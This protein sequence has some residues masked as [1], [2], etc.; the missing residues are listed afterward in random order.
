MIELFFLRKNLDDAIWNKKV[1][2]VALIYI[3]IEDFCGFSQ[4]GFI[5]FA[6]GK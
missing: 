6:G 4:G 1:L 5:D 2:K 3:I